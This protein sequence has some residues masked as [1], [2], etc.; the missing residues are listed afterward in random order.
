MAGIKSQ[1]IVLSTRM[2]LENSIMP[3][4]HQ[5]TNDTYEYCDA[6][7]VFDFT[8]RFVAQFVIELEK[9]DEG[10]LA[11]NTHHPHNYCSIAL[12]STCL[13]V[14]RYMYTLLRIVLHLPSN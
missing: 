2:D 14:T 12:S 8:T 10:A 11:L 4:I 7:F 3:T 5:Y 9:G 6:I 13:L 1:F